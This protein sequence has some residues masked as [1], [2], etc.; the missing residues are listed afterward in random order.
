[1][2]RLVLRGAAT[3]TA[4]F[5]LVIFTPLA[6]Q[7][8]APLRVG[9]DAAPADAIALLSSGQIDADYVTPDAA[10]RMLGALDLYRRG[11]APVIVTSGSQ[12]ERGREQAEL[13]ASWLQRA[14]VPQDSLVVEGGSTRTYESVVALKAM[15]AQRGWRSLVLVTT[16]LDVLR[17]RMVCAK[18]DVRASILGVPEFR[19][20]E[21]G[22]LLYLGS[23]YP[24]LYHAMYEYAAIAL[25]RFRGWL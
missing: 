11:F 16:D 1:M 20:P 25:Y 14:G 17:L 15:M 10:Q 8:A 9:S 5:L 3:A 6:W 13:E 21:P 2:T 19:A 4:L 24:L 7:A 23:G 18:L 12:H 22:S